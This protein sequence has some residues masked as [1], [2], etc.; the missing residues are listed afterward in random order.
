MSSRSSLIRP[1]VVRTA[2]LLLTADSEV[3]VPTLDSSVHS[4]SSSVAAVRTV[5][6]LP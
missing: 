2:C 6:V 4:A 1:T 3:S 5:T